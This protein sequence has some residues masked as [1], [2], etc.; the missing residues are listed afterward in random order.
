MPSLTLPKIASGPIT[1]KSEALMNPSTNG[2]SLDALNLFLKFSPNLST[3]FSIL[4][5]V[6]SKPP[7]SIDARTRRSG[8]PSGRESL[9][10]LDQSGSSAEVAPRIVMSP[11]TSVIILCDLFGNRPPKAIPIAQPKIMVSRF[12]T[13]PRPTNIYPL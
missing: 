5:A 1:N 2:L 9:N 11:S 10:S 6:P 13:V 8:E 4:R 12:I 3:R 7:R